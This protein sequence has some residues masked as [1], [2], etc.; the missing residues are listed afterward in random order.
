MRLTIAFV[1]ERVSWS[2]RSRVGQYHGAESPGG[3]L[4]RT[5]K[6][7]RLVRPLVIPLAR[8]GPLD[9]LS[10]PESS[11]YCNA[12]AGGLCEQ[13]GRFVARCLTQTRRLAVRSDDLRWWSRPG[14][15]EASPPARTLPTARHAP[16]WC[17]R[18]PPPAGYSQDLAGSPSARAVTVGGLY[19]PCNHSFNN[20]ACLMTRLRHTS[21]PIGTGRD[22]EVTGPS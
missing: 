12:V 7:G 20:S 11:G 5:Q 18:P 4:S 16:L 6:R 3:A 17:L 14:R 19:D 9:R 15:R 8:G 1:L 22:E 21:R 10:Q 13:A 2:R